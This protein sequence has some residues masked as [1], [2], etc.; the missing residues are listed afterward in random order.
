MKL[1][2]LLS[3]IRDLEKSWGSYYLQKEVLVPSNLYLGIP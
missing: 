3:F 1:F 2:S